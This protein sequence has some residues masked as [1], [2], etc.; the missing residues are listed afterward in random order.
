M[1]SVVAVNSKAYCMKLMFTFGYMKESTSEEAVGCYTK[2]TSRC[3]CFALC[4][5]EQSLSQTVV[6]WWWL[7]VHLAWIESML[8]AG[9][10]ADLASPSL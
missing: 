3:A 4:A 8:Q 2:G 6:A 1:C 10:S 9:A 7:C 5:L